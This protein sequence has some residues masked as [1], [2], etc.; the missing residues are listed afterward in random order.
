[1]DELRDVERLVVALS[2][3]ARRVRV[4]STKNLKAQTEFFSL[5][6]HGSIG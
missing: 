4:R 1:M 2:Q 5:R 3:A 6:E